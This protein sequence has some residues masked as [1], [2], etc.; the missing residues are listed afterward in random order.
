MKFIL[1]IFFG[2]VVVFVGIFYMLCF[3]SVC[4]DNVIGF[5]F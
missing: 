5:E 4:G 1:F 3:G 2:V